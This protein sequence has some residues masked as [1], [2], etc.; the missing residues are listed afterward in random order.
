MNIFFSD[1]D[2]IIAAQNLDDKRVIKMILESAQMLC[3]ALRLNN[4]VHLAQY[5]ATH[6]NHPSNVWARTTDSNYAWLLAHFKALCDEYTFRYGKVHASA[7]QYSN[8]VAGQAFIPKGDLTPFANCAARSDMNID[9]KWM[10]DT[11]H[12]YR[13]YLMQRWA[14]DIKKAEWTKRGYPKFVLLIYGITN[15]LHKI[16]LS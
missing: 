9:Y 10:N 2:P 3:T 1:A 11:V 8:F 6:G 16:Q 15:A 7:A 12:A 4:A 13:L 5:K 14:S